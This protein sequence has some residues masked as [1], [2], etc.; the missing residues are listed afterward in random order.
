[1]VVNGT[2][3]LRYYATVYKLLIIKRCIS[4]TPDLCSDAA[5]THTVQPGAIRPMAVLDAARGFYL[6]LFSVVPLT[7]EEFEF[8]V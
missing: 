6:S 7:S 4:G 1:M 3:L 2:H 8:H 5:L